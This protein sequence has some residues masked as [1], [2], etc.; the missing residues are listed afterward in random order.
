MKYLF[1]AYQD[2]D[3]WAS[4]PESER[5]LIEEACAA[6][7]QELWQSGYLFALEDFQSNRTAV[8]VQVVNGK[9]S[10]TDSTTAETKKRLIQLFLVNARDLNEAIQL[11]SKMPQTCKGPIEVRPILKLDWQQF[12][13]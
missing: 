6:H 7:E 13:I 5:E 11:I 3:Q 8:T 12:Q 2:E 4:V 10:L 9:V 1:L